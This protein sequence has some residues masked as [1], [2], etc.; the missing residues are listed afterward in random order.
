[1]SKSIFNT[2]F[3]QNDLTGKIVIGLERISEVFK[4]LL[5]EHAKEIG[6]SPIQ[7]QILI[8]VAYHKDELCNVSHLAKE[9]SIT[10][11]TI[12]D[13]VRVL[14]AKLLIRKTYGTGDGRSYTISLSEEGTKVVERTHNFA[15]PIKD[16][17][18]KMDN[19]KLEIVYHTLTKLIY[20]L[21][22]NGVIG[23]QRMCSGCKFYE[24]NNLNHYCHFIKNDI[25][26]NDLK[27]DCPEFE[28]KP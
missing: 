6:L 28:E 11:P 19:S 27:M 8:F 17:L 14:E 1:M 26:P 3:Q 4:S 2:E 15:S 20:N 12:S 25:L 23:V 7:I 16:Q 5:W 21:N 18:D 22:K 10:K 13:A 9:F 24:S